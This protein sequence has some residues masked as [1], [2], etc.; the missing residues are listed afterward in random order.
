MLS[1]PPLP[2]L[3]P[4]LAG[5]RVVALDGA[6]VVPT[7]PDLPEAQAIVDEMISALTALAEP[8]ANT[9]APAPP[10]AL[11]LTHLDPPQPVPFHSDSA[12]VHELDHA[13]WAKVLDAGPALLALEFRQLG[14][15]FA[16]PIANGG[17]LDHFSA[18]LHYYGVGLAG[19]TTE[20]DLE[21]VRSAIQ[22]YLTGFRAPNF[23]DHFQQPQRTHDDEIRLRV[24]RVR[25]EVDPTGLFTGDVEAVR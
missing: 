3:P 16:T 18:P 14:G 24:E 23:V 5:K 7:E 15:A 8:V 6:A 13:G 2:F 10:Q 19:E 4:Y 20:R 1:L 11:P 21:A 17:A 25:R 22:P 12:L 9:W